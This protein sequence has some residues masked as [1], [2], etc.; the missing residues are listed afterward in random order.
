MYNAH[1]GMAQPSSRLDEYITGIRQEFENAT[2]TA[3]EN[4]QRSE[5]AYFRL[6]MAGE[7]SNAPYRA[8]VSARSTP[9]QMFP[10]PYKACKFPNSRKTQFMVPPLTDIKIFLVQVQIQEM[11]MVRQ[12]V[13]ELERNQQVLKQR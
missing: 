5:S 4:D 13:F 12:K 9:V 2:N 10:G 1:R 6:G 11:E 8:A 7:M 3:G